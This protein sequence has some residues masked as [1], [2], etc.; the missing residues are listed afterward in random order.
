MKNLFDYPVFNKQNEKVLCKEN[1]FNNDMMMDITIYKL[2]KG[3]Q[4]TFFSKEKEIAILLVLG[5]VKY[6]TDNFEEIGKRESFI[7][8]KPYCLH[9]CKEKEVFIEAIED[10]EIL[11]QLTTNE[12]EFEMVFYNPE[13]CKDETFGA[14]FLDGKIL[15]TVR[16]I[17]DFKNAP[18]SNMVMGEVLTLQGG[19]SSYIP[20]SHPQPEVY[21][22]RYEREE[23]FGACFIGEDAF[24]IKDGSCAKIPGGLTHPQ[25]TA[26]AYTMYYCWMIRHLKDN[27]WTDRVDDERYKWIIEQN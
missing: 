3:E 9:I 5:S 24:K 12:N 27:P 14:G 15:R 4:K 17:F 23:G 16:T 18:Y 25:C 2:K 22:Y 8:D 7:N 20:H 1:D 10:S 26:P 11:V 6:K 21:Y 19:W 13:N